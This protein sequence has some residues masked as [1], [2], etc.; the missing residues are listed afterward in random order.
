MLWILQHPEHRGLYDERNEVIR[1]L[2]S[3]GISK[4]SYVNAERNRSRIRLQLLLNEYDHKLNIR[5]LNDRDHL[6][7]MTEVLLR[8]A[9]ADP[10]QSNP[11]ALLDFKQAHGSK[12]NLV[13][14]RWLANHLKI[15]DRILR[16][17]QN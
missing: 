3:I 16:K 2:Q 6:R 10:M 1:E 15:R 4:E 8:Y 13:R 14:G 7:F 11:N 5:M 12:W 17:T 9:D